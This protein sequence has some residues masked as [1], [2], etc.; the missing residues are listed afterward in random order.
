MAGEPF[1]S[2][3]QRRFDIRVGIGGERSIPVVFRLANIF[4]QSRFRHCTPNGWPLETRMLDVH[5]LRYDVGFIMNSDLIVGFPLPVQRIDVIDCIDAAW[6]A[7]RRV[8]QN[9]KAP[10]ELAVQR[11]RE[12]VTQASHIVWSGVGHWLSLTYPRRQTNNLGDRPFGE[13]DLDAADAALP[14]NAF[15]SI[16]AA[17][18]R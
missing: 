16:I 14:G 1:L 6:I 11:R 8:E 5:P 3:R 17:W 7:L 4:P 2:L 13:R 9:K 15:K 18:Q 12:Y 10:A